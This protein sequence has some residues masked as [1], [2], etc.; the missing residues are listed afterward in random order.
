MFA[1]VVSLV[2]GGMILARWPESSAVVLGVL[3]ALE[4]IM[5]GWSYIF[6]GL[7][8]RKVRKT[9]GRATV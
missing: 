9:I 1:G 2:L 6:L 8:A 7:A 3:M 5:H 4:L